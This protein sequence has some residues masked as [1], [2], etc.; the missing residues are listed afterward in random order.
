MIINL[1]G[2]SGRLARW[3]LR[4]FK[5]E[6]GDVH[7]SKT[8]QQAGEASSRLPTDVVRMITVKDHT[9]VVAIDATSNPNGGITLQQVRCQIEVYVD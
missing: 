2:F 5:F 8:K 7:R 3:C 1:L 6:L 4:L 9:A